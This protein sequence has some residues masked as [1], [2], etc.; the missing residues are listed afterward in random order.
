MIRIL[1]R[2]GRVCD[3]DETDVGDGAVTKTVRVG[4]DVEVARSEVDEVTEADKD[5]ELAA[6]PP[7]V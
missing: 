4:E 3:E 5:V 2:D 1:A 7:H 6:S